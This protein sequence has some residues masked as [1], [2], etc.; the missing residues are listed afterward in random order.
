MKKKDEILKELQ[1]QDSFLAK[2]ILDTPFQIPQGYFVGLE[3]KLMNAVRNSPDYQTSKEELELIA[4]FLKNIQRENVYSVPQ[5][6]FEKIN[7]TRHQSPAKII[8]LSSRKWFRV[9]AAATVFG[10]TVIT[11]ISVWNKKSLNPSTKPHSW[12]EQKMK[13]VSTDEI[14]NFVK[15]AESETSIP[16]EN[17]VSTEN[18]REIEKLMQ[19]VSNFEI[20]Q[21]ID[22][23]SFGEEALLN[24]DPRK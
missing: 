6:Y 21:F 17:T 2:T 15:L 24:E 18:R 3:E 4:P 7:F 19:D 5:N 11:G 14:N 12:V 22:E 20:Q 16:I 13:Q 8:S 23:T 9:A 1:E 10:F